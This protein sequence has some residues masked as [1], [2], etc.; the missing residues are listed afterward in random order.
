[1]TDTAGGPLRI[2]RVYEKADAD[3]GFRVLVDRLW[4]R[5]LTQEAAALD[6]WLKDVA[7]SPDL[8]RWWGHDAERMGEF[9]DR[10]RHELDGSPAVETLREAI[11]SHP[12]VTLLYAARDPEVNHARILRDWLDGTRQPP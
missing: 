12:T 7:P 8:R 9:A 2:K 3:D 6:L 5:G 10:Y 4:P 1:M 11:S